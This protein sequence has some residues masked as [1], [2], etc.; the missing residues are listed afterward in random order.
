[1]TVEHDDGTADF[2]CWAEYTSEI[3][4][5]QILGGRNDCK[6]RGLIDTHFTATVNTILETKVSI[7]SEHDLEKST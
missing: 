6:S 2:V 7:F 1:M 4:K 3:W 5:K